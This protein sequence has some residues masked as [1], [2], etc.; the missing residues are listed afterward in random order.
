[1]LKSLL[2]SATFCALLIL[3]G[4]VSC[5]TKG[6]LFLPPTDTSKDTGSK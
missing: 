5:A 1:M 4:P 3:G 6:E 2:L